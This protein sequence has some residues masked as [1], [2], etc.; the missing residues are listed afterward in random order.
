MFFCKELLYAY[1]CF[2]EHERKSL[3]YCIWDICSAFLDEAMKQ[4]DE[5]LSASLLQFFM[6]S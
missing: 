6:D 2:Y 4:G 3:G 1:V 5:A